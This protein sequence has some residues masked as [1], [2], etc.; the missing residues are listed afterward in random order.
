MSWIK[1]VFSTSLDGRLASPI[2]EKIHLGG[3]EDRKVLEDALA[4]SDC[5]IMGSGTLRV[6]KSTCLIRDKKLI[7]Q[8]IQLGKCEQP[9][10]LVISQRLQHSS[11]WLFFQQPIRRW[12]VSSSLD[13]DPHSSAL[14]GYERI[15]LFKNKWAP[16]LSQ[17]EQES[18]SKILIL[19]GGKLF[20][21]FLKEDILDE[22]QITLTPR[23]LGGQHAWIPINKGEYLPLELANLTSWS[24][25]VIE[26]LGENQIM[27]RY[28]RNR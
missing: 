15:L 16:L 22:L 11:T 20:Y 17:L 4:W 9:I 3:N 28:F 14:E 23:I 27:L 13:L 24:L 6:H 21:S 12:L 26:P 18:L 1:A 10:S 2:D 19:G 8:R 25:K 7:E 5:T